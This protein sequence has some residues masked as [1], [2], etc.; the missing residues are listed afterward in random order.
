[1]GDF[2]YFNVKVR[3]GNLLG[4]NREAVGPLC[5]GSMFRFFQRAPLRFGGGPDRPRNNHRGAFDRPAGDGI[6]NRPRVGQTSR[7]FRFGRLSYDR[8]ASLGSLVLLIGGRRRGKE[9]W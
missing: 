2:V 9:G 6:D 1:M 8:L 5:V 7:P 4:R 3:L